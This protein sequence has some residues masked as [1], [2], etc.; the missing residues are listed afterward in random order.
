MLQ[1][2]AGFY[3]ACLNLYERLGKRDEPTCFPT[4]RP[5][6]KGAFTA[7]DLNDASLTFHLDSRVVGNDVDANEMKLVMITGAN[8]GGKSTFLR[9]VG[10][11]QL[12]MQAGMFVPATELTASVANGLFTHFSREEDASMTHG[13]LDE[14]LNRMST[15]AE[16]VQPGSLVLCNES[17]SSTNESEGS[18]IARQL[19]HAFGESGVR[20]FYV[21]HLYDLAKGFHDQRRDD[22]L[23][24]RAERGEDGSRPFKLREAPP[25]PTSFGADSYRKIF[26]K[27]LAVGQHGTSAYGLSRS[28]D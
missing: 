2:E 12:M 9:S 14:E 13:K 8:Q 18:E 4:P 17:F 3:V 1:A 5:V 25:L 28:D 24:L 15:I 20:A 26:G 23:F 19:I 27:E 11:A 21:T 7:R 22:V 6:G 16:A 10:I